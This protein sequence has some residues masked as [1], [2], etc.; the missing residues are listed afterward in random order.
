MD[1]KPIHLKTP[2]ANGK[3]TIPSNVDSVTSPA[4]YAP[5]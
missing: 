4:T 1:L 5:L 3:L 2:N